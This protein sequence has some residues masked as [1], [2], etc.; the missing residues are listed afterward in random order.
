MIHQATGFLL[1]TLAVPCFSVETIHNLSVTYIS[2]PPVFT[3]PWFNGLTKKGKSSLETSQIFPWRSWDF[4]VKCYP[5]KT[6]QLGWWPPQAEFPP[7]PRTGSLS[8]LLQRR[9]ERLRARR[10]VGSGAG[11]ASGGAR[12]A[13]GRCDQRPGCG[14][15][16]GLV[17]GKKMRWMY[18]LRSVDILIYVINT[19]SIT[20][21]ITINWL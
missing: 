6:N 4:P 17:E 16:K 21:T 12:K 5:N 13:L 9:F 8:D 1:Y 11:T 7:P 15:E 19:I 18:L 14:G 20:I 3:Y 2:I 10:R